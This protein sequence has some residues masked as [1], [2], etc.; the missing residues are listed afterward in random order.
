MYHN[1][2][3]QWASSIPAFLALVCVPLPFLFYRFGYVIR[4]HSKYAA[5]AARITNQMLNQHQE[6]MKASS[7]TAQDD[8]KL[9]GTDTPTEKDPESQI[10]QR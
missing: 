10:P 4:M 7:V 3:I 1:L 2:G 6:P 9:S 5:E 8:R